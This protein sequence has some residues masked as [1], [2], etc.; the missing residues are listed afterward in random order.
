L[1]VGVV[2]EC[3]GVVV[4]ALVKEHPLFFRFQLISGPRRRLLRQLLG[5]WPGLQRDAKRVLSV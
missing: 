2:A 5:L 3:R 1:A 4:G